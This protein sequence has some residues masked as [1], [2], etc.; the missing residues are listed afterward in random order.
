MKNSQTNIILWKEKEN[1]TKAIS[2]S[3]MTGVSFGSC[4]KEKENQMA[5]MLIRHSKPK[6]WWH[7]SYV[8]INGS[9]FAATKSA[10]L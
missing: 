5:I 6:I 2:R 3:D 4:L 7:C 1:G 10:T 9:G 8:G